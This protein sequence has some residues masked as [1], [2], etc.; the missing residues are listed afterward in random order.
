[1]ANINWDKIEEV[2]SP[3]NKTPKKGEL[4]ELEI[5]TSEQIDKFNLELIKSF[6]RSWS[7]LL[8]NKHVKVFKV[9]EI[10]DGPNLIK[11]KIQLKIQVTEEA[12]ELRR[13]CRDILHILNTDHIQVT[14]F[15]V[16]DAL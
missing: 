1:M 8:N 3:L 6:I 5:I 2:Y 7:L 16:K 11:A 14:R 10:I 12:E 9:L 13:F 15:S 4:L